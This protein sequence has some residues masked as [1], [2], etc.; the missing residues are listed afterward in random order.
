MTET[1]LKSAH[2]HNCD[3]LRWDSNSWRINHMFDDIF[4]VAPNSWSL[5]WSRHVLS[6]IITTFL[7]YTWCVVPNS[8]MTMLSGSVWFGGLSG[9]TERKTMLILLLGTTGT[10]CISPIT[11]AMITDWKCHDQVTDQKL[12]ALNV[13][14]LSLISDHHS[15][16]RDA[17]II[18]FQPKFV[19]TMSVT[20][21]KTDHSKK[22]SHD[23]MTDQAM[24]AKIATKHAL[25]TPIV[26]SITIDYHN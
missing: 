13:I 22:N 24:I 9:Q 20:F 6:V 14:C 3:D 16:A 25:V 15:R 5:T 17:D 23:I 1:K 2:V 7:E 21:W 4:F 12:V 19:I 8:K 11:I 10:H 18:L 26:L